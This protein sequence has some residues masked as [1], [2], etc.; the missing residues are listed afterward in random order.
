MSDDPYNEKDSEIRGSSSSKSLYNKSTTSS[1]ILPKHKPSGEG[2]GA[3]KPVRF[4]PG[5]GAPEIAKDRTRSL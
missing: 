3:A 5:G 4:L 2:H 1:I